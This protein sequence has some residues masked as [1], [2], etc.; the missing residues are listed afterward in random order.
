MLYTRITQ[1]EQTFNTYKELLKGNAAIIYLDEV[2]RVTSFDGIKEFSSLAG[3]EELN[4]YDVMGA[5][6][7]YNSEKEK[8]IVW[9]GNK[10]TNTWD[11]DA[12][13]VDSSNTTTLS[14]I[15]YANVFEQT[16]PTTYGT[17]IAVCVGNGMW[18]V[19][20]NGSDDT[21]AELYNQYRWANYDTNS[22]HTSIITEGFKKHGAEICKEIYKRTDLSDSD[23]FTFANSIRPVGVTDCRCYVP[24]M[25]QQMNI[26]TDVHRGENYADKTNVLCN[27]IKYGPNGYWT[28]SQHIGDVN[29]ANY[30][31]YNCTIY[32]HYKSYINYCFFCLH[33]GQALA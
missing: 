10:N 30:A 13:A 14:G 5:V 8:F 31:Y 15:V 22:M 21:T 7:S 18:V 3:A 25:Q 20:N 24:S 6:L 1:D 19:I 17:P 23:L 26:I 29:Y 27:V 33:F 32:N 2:G 12:V 11:W 9:N 28:S 16:V 4:N